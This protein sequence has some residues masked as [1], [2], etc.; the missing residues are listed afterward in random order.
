[1][2]AGWLEDKNQPNVGNVSYLMH[3]AFAP[4]FRV[5]AEYEQIQISS[6]ETIHRQVANILKGHEAASGLYAF[7][8]SMAN[9]VYIGKSDGNL[10]AEICQQLNAQ[11][12]KPFPRGARQPEHRLDVVR[13]ISAYYV[14]PS[15]FE[16]YAKHMESLI[17]RISKPALNANIGKLKKA[18]L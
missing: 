18:E 10:L 5:I 14:Q 7:Y 6:E 12:K 4:E 16:D 11:V 1:V 17:L 9:L 3:R 15:I 13:Y 8:D 2:A